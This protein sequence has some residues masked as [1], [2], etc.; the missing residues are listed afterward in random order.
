MS[1]SAKFRKLIRKFNPSPI[2]WRVQEWNPIDGSLAFLL[3]TKSRFSEH[4]PRS[5]K[6]PEPGRKEEEAVTLVAAVN[7]PVGLYYAGFV[8]ERD[9]WQWYSAVG[10]A[11][12]VRAIKAARGHPLHSRAEGTGGGWKKHGNRISSGD[13]T[14]RE[15]EGA[16]SFL[17][18]PPSSSLPSSTLPLLPPDPFASRS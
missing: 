5:G 2:F 16:G 13:S 9:I 3:M 8:K 11:N 17:P 15:S 14:R 18:E 10:D 7:N 12:D 1:R 6:G 4:N